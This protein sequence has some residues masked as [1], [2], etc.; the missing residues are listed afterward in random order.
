MPR[1][2]L[3]D[4]WCMLALALQ[5]FL[6][7]LSNS[8]KFFFRQICSKV[9][10]PKFFFRQLCS[11]VHSP[12]FFTTKVFFRTVLLS[13]Y[14]VECMIYIIIDYYL[15][16]FMYSSCLK[17]DILLHAS[18][19]MQLLAKIVTKTKIATNSISRHLIFKNFLGG[20]GMLPDLLRNWHALHAIL[21]VTYTKKVHFS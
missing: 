9:H 11:K 16:K 5:F 3:V 8:P 6:Q 7:T 19:N 18:N 20:G 15:Y 1:L 10:S 13:A 4:R 21:V 2:H 12:K 14:S 17:N